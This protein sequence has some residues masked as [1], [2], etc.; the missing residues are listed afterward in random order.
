MDDTAP[1]VADQSFSYE[2]NQ[3][4]DAVVGMLAN[5]PDVATYTFS[6]GSQTSA[7]GYYHIDSNGVITITAAGILAHVNDFE[8]GANSGD[9]DIIASDAA[10]NETTITVTLS[11]TDVDDTAPSVA[12]QSFSYEENQVADAVVGTLANNADVTTYTFSNGSQTSADGYYHIDSNGVITI[13]AAGILAHVNDFEVGANSGDYDIIASDAAGNETTITVTLSETDVDDTTPVLSS[14]D[15]NAVFEHGLVDGSASSGSEFTSGSFFIEGQNITGI[16]IAGKTI[17]LSE[18]AL[19]EIIINTGKGL[20]TV[21]SFND[22]TGELTYSYQLSSAL[23]HISADIINDVISVKVSNDKGVTNGSFN[24]AIHD[25]SPAI[26]GGSQN[27]I[28]GEQITNVIIVLDASGSMNRDMNGDRIANGNTTTLSRMDIAIAS[29]KQL[30]EAYDDLG[31]VNVQLVSFSSSSNSYTN[32]ASNGWL[33]LADAK[34]WLDNIENTS[35]NGGTDYVLGLQAAM[36]NFV[37]PNNSGQTYSYFISDGEPFNDSNKNAAL[38]FQDQWEAFLINNNINESYAV[39]MGDVQTQYLDVVAYAEE[40]DTNA[41]LIY[42][43]SD[44]ASYLLNTVVVEKTGS[45]LV[46]IVSGNSIIGADSEG[47]SLTSIEIDGFTYSIL[48][49]TDGLLTIITNKGGELTV[50]FNDNTYSYLA[51]S[52]S[53]GSEDYIESF[54]VNITD[55]DDDVSSAEFTINVGFPS[56]TEN[57]NETDILYGSEAA[58]I[59]MGNGGDDVLI[60][61]S[62]NDILNGGTG[63]DFIIGGT[64]DDTVIGGAGNDTLRGNSGSDIFYFASD[65]ADNSTDTIVDFANGDT[66]D[67]SDLLEGESA[68][69]DSL[70]GYLQFSFDG[71]DTLISIDKDKDGSTDLT[72]KLSGVDLVGDALDDSAVIQKLLDEAKLTVD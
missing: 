27:I 60:G 38:A 39:G 24:I 50:N 22:V 18:L 46:D 55:G 53:N 20:L 35:A 12:D 8:V 28:F 21:T 16:E 5:N 69:A 51:K 71:T 57:S 64:G 72:I 23:K 7:D 37:A 32:A 4:A 58:D 13:T 68:T 70:A 42:S 11:E 52:N 49:A 6:N 41:T 19:S 14:L 1:T 43:E 62:G 63:D 65:S 33:N 15:D 2:E 56:H 47:A 44:M 54:Y 26:T 61:L 48:D 66:I 67:L 40:K 10:G 31:S 34:A 3:V 30:I 17:S 59:F 45:L 36:N 29:I 25:D 9:Y